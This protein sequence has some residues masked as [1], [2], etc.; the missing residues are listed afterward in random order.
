MIGYNDLQQLASNG[1]YLIRGTVLD[2]PTRFTINGILA[3]ML[4][5]V[6]VEEVIEH[7]PD[8]LSSLEAGEIIRVDMSVLDPD[9]PDTISN[10][11]ELAEELPTPDEA[12]AE[13]EE[14]LLFLGG[15]TEYDNHLPSFGILGYGTLGANDAVTWEGFSGALA[16]TTS[17]LATATHDEVLGKFDEAR[18]TDESIPVEIPDVPPEGRPPM[19]LSVIDG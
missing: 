15:A 13:G 2:N 7:R 5:T 17:D 9:M 16:G 3:R 1:D 19:T 14:V 6:R 8:A 10:Y 18:P 4:S 12:L 11:D